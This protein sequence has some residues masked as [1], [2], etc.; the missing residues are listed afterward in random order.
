MSG[1]QS[2]FTLKASDSHID[3]S[4]TAFFNSFKEKWQNGNKASTSADIVFPLTLELSFEGSSTEKKIN[5]ASFFKEVTM[6]KP[7]LYPF[8]FEIEGENVILV[9]YGYEAQFFT[10]Y[11]HR[12]NKS[13]KL[14]RVKKSQD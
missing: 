5:A 8:R 10:L 13:W 11:F 14:V 1:E 2:G 7:I 9:H 4:F 6:D 12:T 3:P